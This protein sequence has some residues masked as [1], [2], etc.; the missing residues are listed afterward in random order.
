MFALLG[1]STMSGTPRISVKR[2]LEEYD[3]GNL[4]GSQLVGVELTFDILDTWPEDA[5]LVF[6]SNAGCRS[7][8]TAS[9]FRGYQTSQHSI[10]PILGGHKHKTRGFIYRAMLKQLP[11]ERCGIP[12]EH[13]VRTR[14]AKSVLARMAGFASAMVS[15][16][17]AP[18]SQAA[19]SESSSFRSASAATWRRSRSTTTTWSPFWPCGTNESPTSADARRQ[20]G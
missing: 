9:C 10:Q 7:L 5:F 20:A 18:P 4:H 11:G 16:R 12:L 14:W 2:T 6:Y 3:A 15:N 8:Q 19:A 13:I 17:D 1:F